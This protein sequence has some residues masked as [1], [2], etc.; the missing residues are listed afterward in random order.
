MART[1]RPVERAWQPDAALLDGLTIAAVA[2]A[3]DGRVIYA[4]SAALDLFGSPFDD[5][6]GADARSRLFD[7]PDRGAL[8]QV[9][10]LVGRT[11]SWTGELTM[12][13]SGTSPLAMRTSWTP[14]AEP[15]V[16]AEADRSAVEVNGGALVLIEGTDESTDPYAPGRPLGTRLRRL[17]EV[18]SELLAAS[19]VEAVAAIVTDHMMKA[20]GATSASLSLM[21]DDETLALMALRGGLEGSAGRWA[22]YSVEDN[23][24]TAE[25]VRKGRPVLVRRDE[26]EARYPDL[27]GFADGTGSILCLPLA[28]AG[29][30]V[31]GAVSLSFPGRRALSEAENLFLQLLADSCAM[32][33]DR[34]DAQRAAR[35]REAKLAFLAET[36]A[37]LSSDLD[38]EVTL[39]S[40]AEAAVPWFADWCAISLAEDGLLRTIA[41]AHTHPERIALV[42]ELQ[43]R[44][45][46]D[47]AS[48]QG[49]YR[50]LRTG[51]SQLVPEVTDELLAAGA[52]DEE[53]LEL[54]RALNLSS[55]LSCALKVGDRTFGVISWV[56]GEGGRRFSEDDLAFGEDLAQRAA[57]AID[58]AQLHS[59]VRTAALELQRAVLPDHLP[60]VAGWST[61]VQYLPAGRSEA[62]GDFYDVIYL[63]DGRVA[64]FV[65]DV[66]GRGVTAA[67]VMAQM[68]SAIR[69]LIAVDPEPVPVMDGMDR[70][71]DMLHFEQLVTM[72]YAVA[73]PALDHL[74]VI[75][76]GHPPPVLIAADGQI[77]LLEHPST[78]ILGVGGGARAVRS[79]EFRPGDRLL[80]YTDG[81]V[82]RRREDADTS[83]ARLITALKTTQADTA[84]AW[85]SSIVEELR[86]PT[87]DDDVA[88][89]LV[90]RDPAAL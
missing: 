56:A 9:L 24:P 75:N 74:Q 40:V 55:G 47:P 53:H 79:A 32:T 52:R 21:V 54:M 71:F 6:V 20:A 63:D 66:M 60:R 15:A 38:Y 50:V 2:L 8:D 49:G 10:K 83:M 44:Y 86:D 27:G 87:R 72:V 82:E 35:D 69:T 43:E 90:G 89:L 84:D 29:G 57:I 17:A 33:L 7:E 64:F 81:L 42:H 76:A 65:G 67:S 48:D 28:V 58:N 70:V 5:L 11:G 85:L 31:L 23:V 26:V 45:P 25:S 37:K 61:T 36:S 22:T 13:A 62:G 14:L 51:E 16:P 46:S 3:A 41:V 68:R 34:V 12:L 19:D 18:T 30:R 78:L 77:E 88:A 1:P 59:Q 80:L 73:D 4:N 39:K